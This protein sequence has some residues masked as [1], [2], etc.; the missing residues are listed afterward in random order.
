MLVSYKLHTLK[1]TNLGVHPQPFI[2]SGHQHTPEHYTLKVAILPK[3]GK[4]ADN[5]L[6]NT[7]TLTTLAKVHGMIVDA[8][9]S[10]QARHK[11]ILRPG[12]G[13]Q[14]PWTRCGHP[15]HGHLPK[16]DRKA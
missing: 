4:K 6:L 12:S 15:S 9:P 8:F 16:P 10:L 7:G 2:D 5:Y 3:T 11:S 1:S 14:Q 13:P